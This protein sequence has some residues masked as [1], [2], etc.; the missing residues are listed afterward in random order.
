M[1]GEEGFVET[2]MCSHAFEGGRDKASGKAFSLTHT[3]RCPREENIFVMFKIS[4]GAP[5]KYEVQEM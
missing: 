1:R 4:E 3:L 5:V 2:E